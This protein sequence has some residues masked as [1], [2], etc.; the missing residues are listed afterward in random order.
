MISC[1]LQG[2]LGNQ[3]FQI[4]ATVSL[5]LSNDDTYSFNFHQCY[6]PNQGNQ[7][8][9]YIDNIFKNIP[10]HNN[11]EFEKKYNEPKFSFSNIPYEK[12]LLLN[13][14]FQSEKYFKNNI[15]DIKKLFFIS[16]KNIK[17]ISSK[18]D[19][20]NLTCVHIRRGDYLKFKDFHFTCDLNYYQK[21]IELINDTKFIFVSDDMDWVK[22]NF[23]SDN[24]LYSDFDDEILDFTLI[25]MCKNVIIS[26]SSFSWWGS[27]LN[28]NN[29][30]IITPKKWFGPTGP[31]DT[32]DI[33]PNEWVSIDN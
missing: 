23:K 12:N 29:G 33:I 22:L 26:N 10:N 31:K 7:S 28:D 13:G 20:K 6:T 4:A 16:D 32:Q 24:F 25:T 27:Y 19:I 5:A 14:Y 2:G 9:K 18:Y 15:N 8:I 11:Y 30:K 17:V 1:N 3:M 21:A